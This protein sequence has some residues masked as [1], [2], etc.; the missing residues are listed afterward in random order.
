MRTRAD[1]R[2]ARSRLA[3]KWLI[4]LLIK[5]GKGRFRPDPGAWTEEALRLN[6]VVRTETH[7]DIRNHPRKTCSRCN[8]VFRR[9]KQEKI[10]DRDFNRELELLDVNLHDLL[11]PT[12]D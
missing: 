4:R 7:E 3:K 8:P 12:P 2:A 10:L 5:W 11:R 6:A 9:L 1:R